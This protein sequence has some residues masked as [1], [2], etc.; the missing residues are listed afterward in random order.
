VADSVTAMQRKA[1]LPIRRLAI[2]GVG[3]IGGSLAR[4]LREAGAVE[5]IIGVGRQAQN[6]QTAQRLGVIDEWT[7]DIAIATAQAD[8]VVLA[9]PVGA[10]AGVLR[11]MLPA[12][13]D[14]TVITDAGS[15][16]GEVVAVA[17]SILG[18]R[19]RLFVPG[20]PIAGT[21][22]TG[23]EASFP[24]L[25]RHR[26][27]ILTPQPDTSERALGLIEAMWAA[28]GARLLKMDIAEHDRIL[29]ATSHLPHLLAYA[30]VDYMAG[31]DE[32]DSCFALAAGGFFDFTRIASSHP[33]M[34]RDICL[35]N[36]QAILLRLDQY[37][38]QLEQLRDHIERQDTHAVEA[39]FSRAK[40]V[41]D[42]QLSIYQRGRDE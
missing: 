42:A 38:Q 25:F 8:V 29:A 35:Q 36:R 24:E 2:V 41:R 9:T 19:A 33:A 17:R 22:N 3:L 15:V 13:S 4:A 26:Y 31:L 23:V 34:W 11:A 39:V 6:L 40:E 27:V 30:L 37:M 1:G 14:A 28:A 16:K 20:H 10:M 12:L 7:H 18:H 32:A 5:W 21:E